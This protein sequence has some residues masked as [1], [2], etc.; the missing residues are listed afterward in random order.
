MLKKLTFAVTASFLGLT[1]FVTSTYAAVDISGNGNKSKNNV[2]LKTYVSTG[3][4]QTN[5]AKLNNTVV[6]SSSTGGNKANNNTGGTTSIGTGDA[7]TLVDI[8][9]SANSNVLVPGG[10]CACECAS[11]PTDVTISGNGNRSRNTV[12]LLKKCSSW[13]SQKNFAL[14]TNTVVTTTDTGGNT[15]NNN[16]DGGV[17]MTTGGATT[18]VVITNEANSNVAGD[19]L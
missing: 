19:A 7:D 15:A 11:E 12:W 2:F 3:A 10:D 17:D 16:T 14:F 1:L 5:T 8:S 9:N 6:T 13:T 4:S 18:G